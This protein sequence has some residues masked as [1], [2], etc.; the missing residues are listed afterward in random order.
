MKTWT[1]L[2]NEELAER[3]AREAKQL[4]VTS[5]QTKDDR[6]KLLSDYISEIEKAAG[7]KTGTME[8]SREMFLS[9]VAGHKSEMI[10][11]RERVQHLES[12][13]AW[14]ELWADSSPGFLQRLW[15]RLKQRESQLTA[16]DAR[17]EELEEGYRKAHDLLMDIYRL[18]TDPNSAQYNECDTDMCSWCDQV[19][20]LT[21]TPAQ[22]L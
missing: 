7:F 14:D 3:H 10:K 19:K 8:R 22:K 16:K 6:I 21:P 11:A 12:L 1:E 9:F 2:V 13:T 17:I 18:H 5:N 20:A 4:E 15:K